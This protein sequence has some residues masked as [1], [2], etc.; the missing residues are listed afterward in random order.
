MIK[1]LGLILVFIFVPAAFAAGFDTDFSDLFESSS[2]DLS[3]NY[4]GL[5]FG[6]VGNALVAQ[7]D[8]PAGNIIAGL[9]NIFNTG[10]MVFAGG[11]ISYTIFRS[12]INTAQ[13]GGGAGGQGKG[14]AWPTL[15]IIM[16]VSLLMPM[17]NGYSMAQITVMWSVV[18][19]VGLANTMW[20]EAANHLRETGGGMM[21]MA[22]TNAATDLQYFAVN[23]ANVN[24]WN[25]SQDSGNA[26]A[27][28]LMNSAICL[29]VV[30]RQIRDVF[31]QHAVKTGD[32]V[33]TDI[34]PAVRLGAD[35]Q[36]GQYNNAFAKAP[37]T[38]PGN[39]TIC[40]GVQHMPSLCG[41]YTWSFKT[42]N[43]E[44]DLSSIDSSVGG[45]LQQS[46]SSFYNVMQNSYNDVL[47][48]LDDHADKGSQTDFSTL[49]GALNDLNESQDLVFKCEIPE[50]GDYSKLGSC[51]PGISIASLASQYYSTILPAR[52]IPL[53]DNESNLAREK[54]NAWADESIRNGWIMAGQSYHEFAT[55]ENTN[56]EELSG[57]QNYQFELQMESVK[58]I[59][60]MIGQQ[61]INNKNVLQPFTVTSL[62]KSLADINGTSKDKGSLTFDPKSKYFVGACILANSMVDYASYANLKLQA[63]N[64]AT[65]TARLDSSKI[66]E[67]GS[68]GTETTLGQLDRITAVALNFIATNGARLEKDYVVDPSTVWGR[69]RADIAQDNIISMLL[70][71][72]GKLLGIYPF[73]LNDA[74]QNLTA[75][76]SDGKANRGGNFFLLQL[77]RRCFGAD[78]DSQKTIATSLNSGALADNCNISDVKNCFSAAT[79]GDK[80]CIAVGEGILGSMASAKLGKR[81]DQIMLLSNLGTEMMNNAVLYWTKTTKG[82]YDLIKKIGNNYLTAIAMISGAGAVAAGAK[83]SGLSLKYAGVVLAISGAIGEFAAK[84]SIDILQFEFRIVSAYI[85]ML[86]PFGA[87]LAGMFFT[88]GVTLGLYVPLIPFLTFLFGA[89]GWLIAVVEAMVA[90][91]LVALGV[92][93]PSG[94]DLLGKAE[95]AVILLLGIFVRPAAMVIGFILAI[96]L[97]Y[98]A[99]EMLNVGFLQMIV[100]YLEQSDGNNVAASMTSLIGFCGILII[101]VYITISVINQ[102]FSLIYQVP[103]KLL[104]WIGGA[105]EANTTAQMMGE[106]KGGSAQSAGQA[107]GGAQQTASQ[108]PQAQPGQGASVGFAQGW[109]NDAKRQG[110]GAGAEK[111]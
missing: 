102:A 109:V 17:Y 9:F 68:A 48:F 84:L 3:L 104:R 90:A 103:E 107:A 105:P 38:P 101:Y 1:R 10:V 87:T 53:N 91:P 47:N 57:F 28:D 40:F 58:A 110:S 55:T 24:Q 26:S 11:F 97:A 50:N 67:D 59:N 92:T 4:L 75:T 63:I 18:Q 31:S 69:V 95:Q 52:L 71:I 85:G 62:G 74:G 111:D 99:M 54:R 89:I 45:L 76:F 100:N 35:C 56:Q 66:E 83:A 93:H 20:K 29:A 98:V 27:A 65:L 22:D 16:G 60:E 19:G 81:V 73:E 78:V 77:N 12:V 51:F 46:A 106:I 44:I 33:I 49:T 41:Q 25:P 86:L 34:Q 70:N 79:T 8:G 21:S 42:E 88:L 80:P 30:D 7:G 37:G 108:A 96:I 32:V 43:Q 39:N 72:F 15:R 94:H 14:N 13:D 36:P 64:A 5:L 2:T 61:C 6:T 23:G 82:V